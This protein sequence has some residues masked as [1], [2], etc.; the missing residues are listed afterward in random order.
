MQIEYLKVSIDKLLEYVIFARF[1]DKET[2]IKTIIFLCV[3]SHTL[4]NVKKEKNN[5]KKMPFA[6]A[7]R[8]F[9]YLAVNLIRNIY[10]LFPKTTQCY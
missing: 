9:K 5:K 10:N 4:E 7:L 1:L 2:T 6:T 3:S 8:L